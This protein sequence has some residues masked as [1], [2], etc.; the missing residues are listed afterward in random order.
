MSITR[1]ALAAIGVGLVTW[2]AGP[3]V[4]SAEQAPST[5]G[6]R[7][8]LGVVPQR[9]LDDSDTVLMR[10]AG[11]D[12]I[13]VWISWAQVEAHAGQY[14]W[15]A[16]DGLI[17]DAAEAGLTAFPFLFT[18]PAWAARLD[19]NVCY[20]RCT[21]YAPSSNGTRTAYARFAKAAVERYGPNGSFWDANP[22]LPY[23]PVRSWQIWNEQNSPFFFKPQPD[24]K[25]YA[26]LLEAGSSEI[27]AADPH[28]E[29]VLGGVFSARDTPSGVMGSAKYLRRLYRV[30]NVEDSFDSIAIHPYAG[31]V[32]GVFDQIDALRR[33]ARQA[34]D[35]GV[36]LWVTEL[37][38]ASSGRPK[39]ALVKDDAGQARLLTR[40]FGRLLNRADRYHLRGAFW[41]AW[42]DTG[43]GQAVCRWCAYA[44]L[45]SRDGV[46]KPA[47]DAMQ[48]LALGRSD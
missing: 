14:D 17:R 11:I 36:G 20:A 2:M 38:W 1:A 16:T 31:H 23:L 44:G 10:A 27:K 18:E 47:Y 22:D 33:A 4:V 3:P 34:S 35:G 39:E 7:V 43:K 42:R 29:V 12:S 25:A 5:G 40:A 46:P 41:Y 6:P 32:R 37:G 45:V 9:Q 8:S 21:P 28:A 15:A 30:P 48:E 13:R 24:P 26:S 19:G